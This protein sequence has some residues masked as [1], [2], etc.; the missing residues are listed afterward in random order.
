MF[1]VAITTYSLEKNE[2]NGTKKI[3]PNI[4][5]NVVI[6]EDTATE[7]VDNTSDSSVPG[8]TLAIF[9]AFIAHGSFRL[10]TF[11]VSKAKYE[12]PEPSKG[13]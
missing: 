8:S 12:A 6:I 10:D 11:P 7:I 9:K 4:I 2:E 5:I 13:T 3:T 1:F